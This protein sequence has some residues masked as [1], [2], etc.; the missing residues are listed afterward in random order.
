MT[1]KQV[2][3]F[4]ADNHLKKYIWKGRP[5]IEDD[6]FRSFKQICDFCR[7]ANIPLILGGDVFDSPR[8]DSYSV[9]LCREY[10]RGITAGVYWV[11][12]NHDMSVPS[13]GKL[14]GAQ[15]IHKTTVTLG[16]FS[17][18]GLNNTPTADLPETLKALKGNVDFLVMHQLVDILCGAH[19]SNLAADSVPDNVRHVL[20]GDYHVP[21]TKVNRKTSFSYPGSSCLM[22]WGETPL[23]SFMVF[24]DDGKYTRV[25]IQGRQF[26]TMDFDSQESLTL[27][28]EK[29]AQETNSQLWSKVGDTRLAGCV[30]I[31]YNPSILDFERV[32]SSA[33]YPHELWL[34]PVSSD[35]VNAVSLQ[36]GKVSPLEILP[37]FFP[38]DLSGF[39]LA[40]GLLTTDPPSAIIDKLKAERNL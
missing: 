22:N 21:I 36:T 37:S 14:V 4:S 15:P 19:M 31:R 1:A 39:E 29:D 26:I 40:K 38:I 32:I 17:V 18:H 3:A 23:K 24:S 35:H 2:F 20:L 10:L 8:P 9:D 34:E 6:T 11:D 5:K 28:M 33:L 16:K 13:W 30:R 27:F 25:P 12:G 7:S